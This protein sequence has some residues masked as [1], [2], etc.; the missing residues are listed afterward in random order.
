MRTCKQAN[1]MECPY[2]FVCFLLFLV[3]PELHRLASPRL[4]QFQCSLSSSSSSLSFSSYVRWSDTNYM[5]NLL[6]SFIIFAL[7]SL[8][9][10]F[11]FVE[12][13]CQLYFYGSMY[14]FYIDRVRIFT[15]LSRSCPLRLTHKPSAHIYKSLFVLDTK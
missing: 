13:F 6:I 15:E 1:R 5:P 11:V 8:T 4:D 12:F 3:P 7:L 10:A 9:V 14:I 2:F